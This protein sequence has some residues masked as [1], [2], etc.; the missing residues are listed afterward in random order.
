MTQNLIPDQFDSEKLEKG[1]KTA[2]VVTSSVGLVKTIV[3]AVV[4]VFVAIILMFTA[5]KWIGLA[6]LLLAVGMVVLQ[7]FKLKKAARK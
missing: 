3:A 2:G 5:N 4:F 6:L 1:L 7:V